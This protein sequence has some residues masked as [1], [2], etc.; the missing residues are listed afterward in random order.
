[1]IKG[2]MDLVLQ[3]KLQDREQLPPAIEHFDLEP[4]IHTDFEEY[5]L[6]LDDLR[7]YAEKDSYPIPHTDEREGYC[8]DRHLDY[9][10]MGLKDYLKVRELVSGIGIDVEK[11]S[12]ILDLGCASGRVLRQFYNNC[13]NAETNGV[14]INNINVDWVNRYL[15][16]DIRCFQSTVFPHLPYEDNSLDLVTAFSV[17]THVDVLESMWLMEL[18]RILKPGGI[19]YASVHTEETWRNMDE[20]YAVYNA[21]LDSADLLEEGGDKVYPGFNKMETFSGRKVFTINTGLVY[22]TNVFHEKSYIDKMWGAYFTVEGVH[23]RAHGYQDI[24]LLRK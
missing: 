19:L 7:I 5:S 4:E 21:L 8:G 2:L 22:N 1:M 20:T 24:V 9:W 16:P 10:L 17:F 13:P 18:R 23:T 14:D 6:G 15:S 11:L 3:G 12:A